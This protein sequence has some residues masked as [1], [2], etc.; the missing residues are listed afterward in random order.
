MKESAMMTTNVAYT[1]FV[2]KIFASTIHATDG[3][4]VRKVKS[5]RMLVF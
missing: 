4:D 1:K 5:A 3:L 2:M